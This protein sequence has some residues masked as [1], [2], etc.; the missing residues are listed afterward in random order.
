LI[1]KRK[2]RPV[3]KMSILLTFSPKC[4]L[5][6]E[7][8]SQM[9]KKQSSKRRTMREK[10]ALAVTGLNP[11]IFKGLGYLRPLLK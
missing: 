1:I 7:D 2:Q 8:H 11:A 6:S 4:H 3:A 9:T 10:R 5:G